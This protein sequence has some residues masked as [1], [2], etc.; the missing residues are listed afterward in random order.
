MVLERPVLDTLRPL[1]S[2]AA[3]LA[4][5][6]LVFAGCRSREVDC[7]GPYCAEIERVI[8]L[9]ERSTGLSYREPPR[10]EARTTAQVR[11]F[12]LGQ[13]REPRAVRELAG[14]EVAYKRF[15][16]IPDTLRLREFLASLLEEQIIG[17][18]DPSTKVLYIVEGIERQTASLTLT[19]ELVHTLQDQYVNLRGF[20]ELE[21]EN[22]RQTAAQAV[23]EGQAVFEQLAVML[24]GGNVAINLPGGWDRVRQD[25]REAQSSMPIF[26]AA[27]L[28]IQETLIFPYLTGAEF[29]RSFKTRRPGESPLDDIPISTEQVLHPGKFFGQ[30]DNPLRI[31]LGVRGQIAYENTLGEFETRVLLYEY[32]GDQNDAVRGAAGWGGDRYAVVRTPSGDAL[33]WVTAWDSPFDAGEFRE[34]MQQGIERRL[35][36]GGVGEA[37]SRTFSARGR[38]VQLSTAEV[39]GRPLVIYVDV[40]AGISPALVDI[41]ALRIDEITR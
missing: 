19:H 7:E 11:E 35:E 32:T 13:L 23:F 25:I 24:G 15:G 1:R 30:R 12:V 6:L 39:A 4:L 26:S 5:V 21:G 9:I 22:D 10:I 33:A 3:A 40:P 18:Y 20:Q 17:Y 41:S 16:L 28:I 34:L 14:M 27:P 31:R 8:P 38:T 36:V 2:S 37:T 29:I